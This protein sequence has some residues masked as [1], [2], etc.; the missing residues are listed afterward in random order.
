LQAGIIK[1]TLG[2]A[3]VGMLLGVAASGRWRALSGLLF[4]VTSTDR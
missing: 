2:L 1:Q 4:G 3:A